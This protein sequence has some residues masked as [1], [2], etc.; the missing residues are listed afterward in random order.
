MPE[1][2][3]VEVLTRALRSHLVGQRIVGWHPH[4][5]KIR[6]DLPAQ[7]AEAVV[8]RE[9]LDLRRRAKYL[10]MELEDNRCLVFHLGMTGWIE[11][12]G[13]ETPP[14]RHTHLT[15]RLS[16]RRWLHFVDPRRFGSV[17]LAKLES[18]G[19]EPEGLAH[20]G[21]EPLSRS[22]TAASLRKALAGRRGPIKP[23]LLDQRVLAGLGNIYAAEALFRAGIHPT[24]RAG[25]LS[26]QAVRALHRAIRTV[27]TEAIA[28]GSTTP[29]GELTVGVA[30]PAPPPFDETVA[31][32]T[33][34]P[35]RLS[36]Y[37]REGEPCDVCRNG[38]IARITQGGRSTFFCP[39][40]QKLV[41]V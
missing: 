41:T 5:A 7:A 38:R 34:F 4:R 32:T 1:L 22:F 14:D 8:G 18:P 16:N 12:S 10:L 27:L 20:L 33:Y 2:P 21:P 6:S 15:I 24:T 11:V 17:T 37:G 40:C 23:L 13:R 35:I 36:V 3:E 28:A 26:D 30:E 29:V 31:G 25:D 39:T 19:G 9:I